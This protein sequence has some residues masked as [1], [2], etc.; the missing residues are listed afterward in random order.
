MLPWPDTLQCVEGWR[1]HGQ[2]PYSV[3]RDDT[4]CGGMTLPWPDTLQCVEGWRCHGQTPYSVWRDD[5]AMARHLTVCGRMTLSWP[6]T[7]QCVEGWYS[8]WRDDVAM[9]RHLTVCGGMTLP[10]PDTLQYVEALSLHDSP[11]H[12][13]YYNQEV[14]VVRGCYT[15]PCLKD[16]QRHPSDM[17]WRFISTFVL[18]SDFYLRR[19]WH[20]KSPN[21]FDPTNISMGNF[22]I[23]G[24]VIRRCRKPKQ[25][26]I[27]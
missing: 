4:V 21:T 25:S 22:H 16:I 18:L 26:T 11:G 7:L 14:R 27:K 10:W 3:W 1:C 15:A 5:V 17:Q 13:L 8:V 2:T 24:A 23:T 19:N 12:M 6:D 20:W 9:A